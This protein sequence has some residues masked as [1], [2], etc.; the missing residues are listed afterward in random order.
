MLQGVEVS[1]TEALAHEIGHAVSTLIPGYAEGVNAAAAT[2]MLTGF[3]PRGEAY[4]TTFENAWRRQTFFG[5]NVPIRRGYFEVGDVR[6][7]G[8]GVKLFP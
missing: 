3:F 4:A 2:S 6:D 8:A 7:L 1:E 5:P